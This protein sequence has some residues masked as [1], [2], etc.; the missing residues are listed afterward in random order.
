[1]RNRIC[2][3]VFILLSFGLKA[4][5]QI[6]QKPKVYFDDTEIYPKFPGGIGAFNQYIEQNLGWPEGKKSPGKVIVSF[7]IEKNGS[8]SHARIVKP[9][10]AEYDVAVL[11]VIKN[12]PKWIPGFI[13][14]SGSKMPIRKQFSV[15]IVF[16]N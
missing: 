3:A 15:P 14:K 1:M 2:L 10:S 12:S 13:V 8:V 4:Q 9:F 11:K 6:K 5:H 7:V 16:S